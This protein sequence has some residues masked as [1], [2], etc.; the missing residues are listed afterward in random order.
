MSSFQ[1]LVPVDFAGVV[2]IWASRNGSLVHILEGPTEGI[3][4]VTW[5]PSGNIIA[6]GS[7]DF[8]AWIWDAA[9]GTTQQVGHSRQD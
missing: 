7:E 1:H 9:D 8:T 5:H 3:E 6:A 4:W 2:R